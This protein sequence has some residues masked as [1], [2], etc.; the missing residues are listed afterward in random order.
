MSWLAEIDL[1]LVFLFSLVLARI[2]GL[3]ATAPLLSGGTVP[4]QVR[5]LFVF[6][7]SLMT[8]SVQA[9]R[10]IEM[11]NTVINYAL[12]LAGELSIG[13]LLGLGLQFFFSGIQMAGLLISQTSGLTLADVYNP[14]TN[15]EAPLFSHLM[16]LLGMAV[17][18][19][20]GG[21]RQLMMGLLG[22]FETLPIGQ[23]AAIPS[24]AE[25][26]TDLIQQ[27]LALG[28]RLAAPAVVALLLTTLVLGLISRTLPQ[29]N[30]MSFGFG[31]NA[32]VT[33]AMLSISLSALV[34]IVQDEVEPII[35]VVLDGIH[36]AV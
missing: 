19:S 4:M 31:A 15:S 25:L 6:A 3:V 13:L 7:L 17:F 5:A 1:K 24:V 10:S 20:V 35:E 30:I 12:V 36:A 18:V 16:H 28:L 34:W 14:D 23:L 22:T 26:F 21:H 8:T 11:P 29:L 27:S 9:A 32:L 2:S 33:L